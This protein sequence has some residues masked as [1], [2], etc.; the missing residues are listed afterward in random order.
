MRNKLP[1]E[2]LSSADI[3]I[4]TAGTR[5]LKSGWTM[6]TVLTVEKQARHW[7]ICEYS[8]PDSIWGSWHY[9]TLRDAKAA[10]RQWLESDHLAP[11]GFFRADGD[12]Y[13]SDPSYT[14]DI[15]GFLKTR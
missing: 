11:S 8:A 1:F 6:A 15:R 4:K 5:P 14:D 10:L 7:R 3:R 2:I 9:R 13:P 12:A